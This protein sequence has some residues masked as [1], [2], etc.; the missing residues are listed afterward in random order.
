MIKKTLLAFG[1]FF[2]ITSISHAGEIQ[3][4]FVCKIDYL[5]NS[6][7]DIALRIEGNELDE[8]DLDYGTVSGY[9][10]TY[11]SRLFQ[12]Y[13]SNSTKSLIMLSETETEREINIV[14]YAMPTYHIE[15][16]LGKGKCRRSF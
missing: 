5:D 10:Q 8:K 3:G 13:N 4:N 15:P 1:L 11:I 16:I 2:L 14:T 12:V 7:G 9:S 6:F